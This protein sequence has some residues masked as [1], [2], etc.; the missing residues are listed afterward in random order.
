[1]RDNM[2]G[3]GASH[4]RPRRDE[5]TVQYCGGPA[6]L[7][8][9]QCS[10]ALEALEDQPRLHDRRIRGCPGLRF[11]TATTSHPLCACYQTNC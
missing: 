9:R 4:E 1:V 7:L 5:C 11:C 2:V 10:C 6:R 8:L 3:S